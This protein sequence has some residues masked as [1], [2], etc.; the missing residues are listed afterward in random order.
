MGGG[1]QLDENIHLILFF[2]ARDTKFVNGLLSLS[3]HI[4]NHETF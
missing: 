3:S 1:N 2:L 4:V